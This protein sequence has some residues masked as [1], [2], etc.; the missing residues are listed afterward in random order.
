MNNTEY[1]LTT[2]E[3]DELAIAQ[4]C[5]NR[6]EAT[7]WLRYSTTH[8]R[9]TGHSGYVENPSGYAK[10]YPEGAAQQ[11]REAAEQWG[12]EWFRS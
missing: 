2:R 7:P 3:A 8:S 11:G 4:A 5:L 9:L 1:Q 6:G 10:V 12:Y